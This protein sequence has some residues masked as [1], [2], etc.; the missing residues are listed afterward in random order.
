VES[1]LRPEGSLWWERFVKKAGLEPRV[2]ER[3]RMKERHHT[4]AINSSLF[5][6][7]AAAFARPCKLTSFAFLYAS[8]SLWNQFPASLRQPHPSFSISDSP[9][10]TPVTSFSSVDSP[11]SPSIT[12]SLLHSF[13]PGLKPC[14]TNPSRHR[15]SSFL[16]IGS[17]VFVLSSF[18]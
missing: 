8:L 4:V 11:L 14:F 2:K 13:I 1:V 9:L 15:L 16:R 10:P 18:S 5:N 17:L 6:V 7:L 12:Y 3:G